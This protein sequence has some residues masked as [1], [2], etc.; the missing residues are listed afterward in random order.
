MEIGY[1]YGGWICVRDEDLPG[2]LYLRLGKNSVGRWEVRDLYLE[3]DWRAV[4]TADLRELP[5]GDLVSVALADDGE[6]TVLRGI[7]SP[8]P[9]LGI[10]ASHYSTTWGASDKPADW[11]RLAWLT[12]LDSSLPQPK[13]VNHRPLRESPRVP[14]LT[15]PDGPITDD[16]L[17]HVANAYAQALAERQ[18]PAVALAEQSG[19]PVRTVHRWIYLARQRGLLAKTARG[20]QR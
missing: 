20:Q 3:A 18:R 17:S 12:Q 14:P 1:G 11:V 15:R 8:G 6:Q 19:A 13:R 2:P 9:Q 4:V 16:F 10:L 7:D 5:L